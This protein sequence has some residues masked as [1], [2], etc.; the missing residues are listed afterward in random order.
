VAVQPRNN[1]IKV[2]K[3]NKTNPPRIAKAVR[4][5]NNIVEEMMQQAKLNAA[6]VNSIS[7][8]ETDEF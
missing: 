5:L 4:R 3:T 1:T 2:F 6:S 7:F 8:K